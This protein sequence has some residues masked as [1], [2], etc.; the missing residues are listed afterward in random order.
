MEKAVGFRISTSLLVIP[1]LFFT[2][3]KTVR[4]S[5]QSSTPNIAIVGAGIGGSSSC[6]FIRQLFESDANIDVFEA[7]DRIGGRLS[8]V[9]IAGKR[10]E[11]GGSIIHPDNK[12]MGDFVKL[13][14]K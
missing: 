4:A 7:S 12:Y 13:L 6:H 5:G 14:G 11:S 8:T 10:F 9:E 3:W 2:K 1:V